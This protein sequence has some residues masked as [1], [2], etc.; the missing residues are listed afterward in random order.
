MSWLDGSFDIR[1]LDQARE[2]AESLL[3]A[4]PKFHRPENR[5]LKSRF[6]QFWL[7]ASPDLPIS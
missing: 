5:L 1:L 4:D 2:S 6:E 7:A 3:N